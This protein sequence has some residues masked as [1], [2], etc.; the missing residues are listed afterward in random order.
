[1]TGRTAS[2]GSTPVD[3]APGSVDKTA[4][5]V[6]RRGGLGIPVRL[7]HTNRVQV[8]NLF[9][10]VVEEHGQ[11]DVF[12]SAVWGGNERLLD[13]FWQR[14][15]WDQPVDVWQEYM[16]AG[17]HAFWLS[18][19]AAAGVMAERRTG[20]IVAISEPVLEG[21][22]E[23]QF[24]DMAEMFSRLGHSA[25]NGLVRGL[26]IDA[27]KAGIAVIGLL[28]GFMKTERVE[29]HLQSLG[30]E[31][32]RQFRYDLAETPEY[33]GRAVVALAGDSHAITRT[34][35]LVYVADL[36][37]AYGFNDADGIRVGNYYRLLGLIP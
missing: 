8:R 16:E 19:H 29:M 23:G 17:P 13:P 28:P 27:E 11:L 22:Y 30:E 3:G 21:A 18:A 12:V 20:L 15:F 24:P 7:D 6:T 33:A 36:A 1:V 14:P 37:E 9:R 4:G 34:G 35:Q 31:A 2:G 32:R 25:I 5:E 26:S 10:R